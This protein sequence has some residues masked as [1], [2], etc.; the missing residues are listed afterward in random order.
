MGLLICLAFLLL[1]VRLAPYVEDGHDLLSVVSY[2]SLAF[3]MLIGALKSSTEFERGEDNAGSKSTGAGGYQWQNL[4]PAALGALLIVINAL[5]FA[6]AV[7]LVVLRVARGNRGNALVA[8]TSVLPKSAAAHEGRDNDDHADSAR[9]RPRLPIVVQG[10]TER[11]ELDDE[12]EERLK[13]RTQKR[14]SHSSAKSRARVLSSFQARIT[15]RN[16]MK[17]DAIHANMKASEEELQKR[18]RKK[19]E[20]SRRRTLHRLAARKLLI[21]SRR[22][23]QVEIFSGLDDKKLVKV[24]EQ[25]A[26]ASFVAGDVIVA[27]GDSSDAFFIVTEG[28]VA[29]WRRYPASSDPTLQPPVPVEPPPGSV[30]SGAGKEKGTL[31]AQ[32]PVWSH[33]GETACIAVAQRRAAEEKGGEAASA[34]VR[35]ATVV[36]E[37]ETVT[38]LSLSAENL[39]SLFDDGVLDMAEVLTGVVEE[40]AKRESRVATRATTPAVGGKITNERSLFS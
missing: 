22:L 18:Q 32:L 20:K 14:R 11:R 19:Q 16:A 34:P 15:E 9:G 31:L 35:N 40:A 3:T 29:V 12:S 8:L 21:K 10:G 37:S 39:E 24:V 2:L 27:Q 28:T 13:L 7:V 26:C 30:E 33:F 36:A 1:I 17:A 23:R 4:D 38:V 6:C 25:M 5:P